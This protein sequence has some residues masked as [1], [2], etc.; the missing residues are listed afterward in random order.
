MKYGEK[1]K[2]PSKAEREEP[3]QAAGKQAKEAKRRKPKA[4]RGLKKVS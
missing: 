2:A 4:A 3:A 1:Q